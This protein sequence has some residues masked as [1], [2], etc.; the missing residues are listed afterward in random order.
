MTQLVVLL[1]TL[2]RGVSSFSA[3]HLSPFVA[4]LFFFILLVA[5]SDTFDQPGSI[6]GTLIFPG[7]VG[8]IEMPAEDPSTPAFVPGE[9][10]VKFASDVQLQS[11]SAQGL[12]LQRTQVAGLPRTALY[13]AEGLD[14]RGTVALVDALNAR[15]DVLYAELNTIKTIQKVPNDPLYAYQ[16]HYEAMNLPTAWDV[17]DGVGRDVT[18][19]VIDSGKVAHPDLQGVWL[20]GYDFV[21]S[22]EDS[23]D[24][25]G[26]D[27]DPTDLGGASAYHGAH[28]AG[29]VAARTNN[30][31]GVAGVSWGAKVVPVR[32]I[33]AT[34]AGTALDMVNGVLWAAGERVAGVPIN[35][36]PAQIINLSLGGGGVCQQS[37]QEAFDRVRAKGV[38]VVVA[39]GNSNEDAGSHSPASCEGVVTVGATGPENTRAPYSNYGGAVDVMAPGGDASRTLTV[40]GEKVPAGVLS[41]LVQDGATS[42]GPYQG[43]SMAAPHIA[44]LAALM[45][46]AEPDSSPDEVL[47]KLK[48]SAEPLSDADCRRAGG[49]GAGLVNA[50]AALGLDAA[51]P[52]PPTTTGTVTT[53][54]VAF[55]CTTASC[56]DTDVD[57]SKVQVLTST[58]LRVPFQFGILD[59]GTYTLVAWQD[60]DNNLDIDSGEP[61]GQHPVALTLRSGG[62]LERVDIYLEAASNFEATGARRSILERA[63][64]EV[65]SK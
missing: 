30:G 8:S 12:S 40:R 47:A 60:L 31:V 3:R 50:A 62:V 14:A 5:C 29:T 1:K 22:P 9:V 45:L 38:T 56:S 24:G 26:Y 16:W 28:V 23:A 15:P 17:E 52:V 44:G 32:V 57:R 64:Q 35:P 33:G 21:S 43:T 20:G 4:T 63:A 58:E 55:Y 53:Y 42:Y 41:T 48:E 39:A 27:A 49:C 65:I 2:L 54:V 13:R 46:A 34:G 10:I 7:A 59:P 37:E 6:S 18:V 61:L 25:D 11:L 51:N 19:A 36:N